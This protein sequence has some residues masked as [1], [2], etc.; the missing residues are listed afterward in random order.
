MFKKI[1]IIYTSILIILLINGCGSSNETKT[2][3]APSVAAA[4]AAPTTNNEEPKTSDKSKSV[5]AQ[6]MA[7]V[8]DKAANKAAESAAGN[9]TVASGAGW[10]SGTSE[11]DVNM[12]KAEQTNK[13]L[14]AYWTSHIEYT[15]EIAKELLHAEYLEKGSMTI[16]EQ[17]NSLKSEGSKIT[18]ETDGTAARTGSTT[19][20]MTVFVTHPTEGELKFYMTFKETEKKNNE[21]RISNVE[22]MEVE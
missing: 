4:A 17:I 16:D 21:W 13:L 12:A 8:Q 10:G 14:E 5:D 9:V 6:D 19:L 20:G 11:F 22:E 1:T 15:P 2:D 3:S 7:K 18:F